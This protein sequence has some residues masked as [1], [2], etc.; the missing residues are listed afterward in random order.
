MTN[1][2]SYKHTN[3]ALVLTGGG[4]RAAYQVGVLSAIAQFIPR[5]H[6]CPFPIISGTSAG[7]INTTA[8]ACYASCFQL[9]VKKLEWV[10]NNLSTNRIYHSDPYRV[11][12]HIA[13][14]VFGSFQADYANRPARSLLNNAPLRELLNEVIDFRRIDNNILKGYL[15]AVA[16][17][18]SSY[19]SGDSISFYQSEDHIKP[20]F[21]ANR[22]G[23]PS[24]FNSEHLMASA[25]IP[26][27][28]PSINIKR[29]H[30]G[31]GSV[32]QLS[33][34]SPAVHLGAERIFIVGVEQP[35]EPIH[36][37]E[38]NPHPPT[39]S[40]IAGHL[41]DSIFSDTLQSDI[42]RAE[43][44]NKTIA[45][46][47]DGPQKNELGLKKIDTLLINPSH[48]F[49]SMAVKYFDEL[50]LSIKILLRSVGITNDSESS[51]VSYLLFDKKYC[52]QLIKLGY[53]DAMEKETIIRDFLDL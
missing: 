45:L 44:I 22:R 12:S 3:N 29:Q 37:N 16:V 2:R 32:H 52:K 31:D 49:N 10:W 23:E 5:N 4:A 41:L 13:K 1:K 6:G 24:Q 15:S 21:R 28:F 43:R 50:P 40:S 7:A 53:E 14:G 18:A 20:W 11:F 51:L 34:L 26:L 42:E 39:T 38:N 33:P 19:T 25:A 9:G 46:S 30:F 35:K 8:L 17:T 48:D 47:P 36:P 27:V